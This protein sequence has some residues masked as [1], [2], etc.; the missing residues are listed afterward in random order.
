[1]AFHLVPTYVRGVD[2]PLRLRRGQ[3]FKH[4]QTLRT[5]ECGAEVIT[6]Y[7]I[8]DERLSMGHWW[9]NNDGKTKILGDKTCPSTTLSTTNPTRIPP[10]WNLG[11]R[12]ERRDEMVFLNQIQQQARLDSSIPLHR[13]VTNL[14]RRYVPRY[15]HTSTALIRLSCDMR[16]AHAT[17]S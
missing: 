13:R 2:N 9:N 12:G 4:T 3:C 10:G 5:S 1:L 16:N 15:Y 8:C 11:L 7:S 17:T 6:S 14:S